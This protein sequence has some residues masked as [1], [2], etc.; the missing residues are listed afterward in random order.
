MVDF[1]IEYMEIKVKV[2]RADLGEGFFGPFFKVVSRSLENDSFLREVFW[3]GF[4]LLKENFLGVREGPVDS[5]SPVI[6]RICFSSSS[7][8]T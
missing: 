4:C 8:H 2:H 1:V 6:W 5:G 7:V 3:T